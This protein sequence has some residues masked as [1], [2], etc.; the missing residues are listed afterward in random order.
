MLT[1]AF[2]RTTHPWPRLWVAVA[3]LATLA[4]AAHF[5]GKHSF[6][7]DLFEAVIERERLKLGYDRIGRHYL[8]ADIDSFPEDTLLRQRGWTRH[9]TEPGYP[10]GTLYR[11]WMHIRNPVIVQWKAIWIWGG[12]L[13]V[14]ALIDLG[15][16][17]NSL[18]DLA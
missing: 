6:N 2:S 15:I 3:G 17:I 14:L 10:H 7:F 18:T 11:G 13:L 16:L 9:T 5:L 1:I 12:A 8:L 4:A